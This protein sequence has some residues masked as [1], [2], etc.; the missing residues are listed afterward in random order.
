M[1]E[2]RFQSAVIA[3]ASLPI[4]FGVKVFLSLIVN[5]DLPF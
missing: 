2:F 4:Y 5:K 3:V 1:G